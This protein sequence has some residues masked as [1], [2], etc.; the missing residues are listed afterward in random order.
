MPWEKGGMNL[1]DIKASMASFKFS[2]IK[3]FLYTDCAWVN[4]LVD[5]IKQTIPEFEKTALWEYIGTRE[6]SR[7]LSNIN[8][9]FWKHAFANAVPLGLAFYNRMPLEII[10][11]NIWGTAFI[12]RNGLPLR[13]GE[14]NTICHFK[15]LSE[16]ITTNERGE[17]GIKTFEQM[18]EFEQNISVDQY[19]SFRVFASRILT[20]YNI[21]KVPFHQHPFQPSFYTLLNLQKKGCSAWTKLLKP[22]FSNNNTIIRREESWNLELN[23]NRSIPAWDNSYKC[24]K[25]IFFD[26]KLKW[27]QLQI[28][29]NTLKTNRIV[30]HFANTD[31]QCDYCNN[32]VETISHLLWQCNI[33]SHFIGEVVSMFRPHIPTLQYDRS[34]FLFGKID[35]NIGSVSYVLGLYIKRYIWKEKFTNKDLRI[36]SFKRWLRKEFSLINEAFPNHRASLT[37]FEIIE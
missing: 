16:F 23:I 17:V 5:S 34:E 8:N 7:A 31:N 30:H 24:V 25:E 10:Y 12:K 15:T 28:N 21:R 11:Q 4:I 33:T 32:G 13:K 9:P 35:D 19:R 2:W 18:A 22:I 1:P 14:F 6:L 3:R 20:E 36:M 29:R 37:I 27:L 26:N